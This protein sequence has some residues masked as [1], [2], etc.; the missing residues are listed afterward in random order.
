MRG[1]V[2]F[3][4]C[5]QAVEQRAALAAVVVPGLL[6]P[7]GIIELAQQGQQIRFGFR[8]AHILTPQQ[9]TSRARQHSLKFSSSAVLAGHPD[10]WT[11]RVG[12]HCREGPAHQGVGLRIL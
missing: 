9:L 2:A 5:H 4:S 11:E 1:K 6:K 3:K 7:F 12:I 8:H 10:S